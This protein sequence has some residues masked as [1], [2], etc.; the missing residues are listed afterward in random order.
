[1]TREKVAL[2]ILELSKARGLDTKYK[3]AAKCFGIGRQTLYNTI[4]LKS[5][6]TVETLEHICHGLGVTLQEFFDWDAESVIL[7]DG[8]KRLLE[9]NR[10]LEEK[11]RQR[12]LA[13][14]DLIAEEAAAMKQ[15][16]PVN[17]TDE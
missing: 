15:T 8:E 1:M 6:P 7:S 2:R 9:K 17:Q 12:L 10:Q 11:D 16:E 14:A 5:S 3:I 13:Y 4:N